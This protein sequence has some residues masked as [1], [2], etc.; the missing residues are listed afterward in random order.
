MSEPEAPG[1]SAT[2]S[3]PSEPGPEPP[4]SEERNLAVAA[5]LLGVLISFLGPLI[6]W[7]I[8]RETAP[9]VKDQATE[10]LNF[11][12]TVLIAHATAGVLMVI[13]IGCILMPIILVANLILSIIAAVAASNGERY[14]YPIAL[15]LIS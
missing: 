15:R 7:L 8:K 14:R 5:H 12:I 11:Q 3:E 13:G 9:F 2:P 6:I 4:P 10:A 1:G